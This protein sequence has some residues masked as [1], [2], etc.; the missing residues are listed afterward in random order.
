MKI[1]KKYSSDIQGVPDKIV[2]NITFR[3][4]KI[5]QH[6]DARGSLLLEQ[7]QH[8]HDT[9]MRGTRL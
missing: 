9:N 8:C 2:Q 4:S 7:L 3:E 1:I 5:L 6:Q